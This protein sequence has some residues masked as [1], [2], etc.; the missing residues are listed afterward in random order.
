MCILILHWFCVV[1]G[2]AVMPPSNVLLYAVVEGWNKQ[3]L[4]LSKG[5]N[6]ASNYVCMLTTILNT[7]THRTNTVC[8]NLQ[9]LHKTEENLWK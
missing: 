1:L 3:S 7:L 6:Y 5:V 4:L 2:V 8:S 9:L